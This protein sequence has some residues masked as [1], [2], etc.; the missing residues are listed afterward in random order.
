[1]SVRSNGF[2]TASHLDQDGY[3]DHSEG[4]PERASA[5]SAGA[6]VRIWRRA[7]NCLVPDLDQRIPG[8]LTRAAALGTPRAAAANNLNLDYQRNMKSWRMANR[9]VL[10]LDAMT[11]ELGVF[12]VEK[13]LIH[14]IFQYLDYQYNDHGAFTRVVLRQPLA[15]RENRLTL[16]ANW[17]GGRIDNQQFQSLLGAQRG[18]LLSTSAD[19][20]RNLALYAENAFKVRPTLDLIAGLQYVDARRER[21]DR[22]DNDVDT[23]GKADYDFFSPKLGLLWQ[24]KA[25]T[26]VFGNLS[27]SGEAPSFGELNFT[28]AALSD[29]RVQ[30]ATTLELGSRGESENLQWELSLYRAELRDEFQFDDLGGGNFQVTNADETVHQ[31]LEAGLGWTFARGLIAASDQTRLQ[32]AYTFN[33]FYFDDDARWGSNELPGAPRHYV[34]A[35]LTYRHASGVYFG[36]NLEWVPQACDVDNANTRKTDR[37]VLAGL[38]TGYDPGGRWS[39]YLDAR[40]LGDERYIASSSIAAV[41]TEASALAEPGAG[42]AIFGG[43]SL[44]WRARVVERVLRGLLP[45]GRC[46]THSGD[47]SPVFAA[48]VGYGAR[49][50]SIGSRYQGWRTAI[51]DLTIV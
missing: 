4:E 51:H 26:Q 14:P 31:G 32:L 17:F 48:P 22:F 1:M 12:A 34:R 5:T 39:L 20:S 40:N 21:S 9:T 13:Q 35:A 28:N 50:G 10:E 29:T 18:N 11:A 38:R 45:G 27:R 19:R 25:M 33:D 49:R 15:G 7:C 47:A 46:S 3:R 44:R 37:Y 41:A 24:A 8:S 23:S 2:I 30:R 42:R 36:P 43:V 6:S 16:G